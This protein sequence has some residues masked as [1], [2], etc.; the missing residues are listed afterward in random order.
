MKNYVFY[1]YPN[2][3]SQI[4]F[5]IAYLEF[6]E[7]GDNYYYIDPIEIQQALQAIKAKEDFILYCWLRELKWF[8][9]RFEISEDLSFTRLLPKNFKIVPYYDEDEDPNNFEI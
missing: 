6:N 7:S 3:S 1:F 5:K 9:N 4:K 8:V 2:L